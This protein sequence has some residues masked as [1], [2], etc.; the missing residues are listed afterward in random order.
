M[1]DRLRLGERLRHGRVRLNQ[2]LGERARGDLGQLVREG[3]RDRRGP[4]REGLRL[5]HGGD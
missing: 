2:R 3:L 5:R 4:L 1:V